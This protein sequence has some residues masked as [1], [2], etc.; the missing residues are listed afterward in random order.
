M[1]QYFE[2]RE[3]D[4]FTNCY[5]NRGKRSGRELGPRKRGDYFQ[6]AQ[7]FVQRGLPIPVD[8]CIFTDEA[9]D[10]TLVQHAHMLLG[11]CA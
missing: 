2:V 1:V 9:I 3:R 10:E 8:I 6:R 5:G 4:F 11:M 7:H